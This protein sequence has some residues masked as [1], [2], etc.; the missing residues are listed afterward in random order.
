M[1]KKLAEILLCSTLIEIVIEI[2]ID[3]EIAER[4]H[5][6]SMYNRPEV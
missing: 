2:E 4:T 1:K 5:V 6:Q 3:I